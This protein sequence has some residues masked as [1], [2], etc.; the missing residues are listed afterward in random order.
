M[1]AI[2]ATINGRKTFLGK[3]IRDSIYREFPFSKAVLWQN[4]KLGF[5]IRLLKYAK[6]HKVKSFIFS[7]PVKAISLKIGVRAAENQGKKG[8][9][10][11]GTQWYIPKSL[12]KRLDKYVRTPYAGKEVVLWVKS[13]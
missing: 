7:D 3:H 2:Y 1:Y 12:M 9:Y 11:E 5:D 6:D 8:E 13:Q 10:G 4:K